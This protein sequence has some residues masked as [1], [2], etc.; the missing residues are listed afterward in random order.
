MQYNRTPF[1]CL[2]FI[3]LSG[4]ENSSS[5]SKDKS[6]AHLL[7]LVVVRPPDQHFDTG[8]NTSRHHTTGVR[9]ANGSGRNRKSCQENNKTTTGRKMSSAH[10]SSQSAVFSPL[11]VDASQL[12]E[13]VSSPMYTALFQKAC[14]S[15]RRKIYCSV[16][17][18][19]SL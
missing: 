15:Q 7:L 16:Y 3:S 5:D 13:H 6:T 19:H 18:N 4:A 1:R 11:T 9:P 12:F 8:A 2:A 14:P 10:S 17:I